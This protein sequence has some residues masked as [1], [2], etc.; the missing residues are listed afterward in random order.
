ST[1]IA[2]FGCAAAAI[3]AWVSNTATT[4]MLLPVALGMLS[5]L[6][7]SSRDPKLETRLLL[8]LAF[9]ASVGGMATPVGTPPN[10]I[11][12]G[13]LERLAGTKLSFLDWMRMGV[14]LSLASLGFTAFLLCRGIETPAG[15]SRLREYLS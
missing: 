1:L 6:P 10:L 12:M 5:A 13:M 2:G 7:E 4:A 14:P 11:G 3:S 15:W 9:A 8:M